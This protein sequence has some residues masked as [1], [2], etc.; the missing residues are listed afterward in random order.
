MK[1]L[2][3]VRPKDKIASSRKPNL[4]LGEN[5]PNPSKLEDA[6]G[7]K[8]ID[9]EIFGQLQKIHGQTKFP[10]S[11]ENVKASAK[12]GGPQNFWGDSVKTSQQR[13]M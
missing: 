7:V 12:K 8:F 5:K 11:C 13:G 6:Q 10:H 4:V 3:F 9:F 2:N 1:F